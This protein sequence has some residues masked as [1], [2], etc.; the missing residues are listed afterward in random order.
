MK[1]AILTMIAVI[2][3]GSICIGAYLPAPTIPPNGVAYDVNQAPNAMGVYKCY[4]NK[5]LAGEFDVYASSNRVVSLADDGGLTIGT[6]VVTTDAN[7][8]KKYVYPWSYIPTVQGIS[9][10][11]IRMEDSLAG[12]NVREIVTDAAIDQPVIIGGCRAFGG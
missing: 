4:V 2:L 7:N 10:H 6:P 1:R 9:Y 12:V 3:I 5:V 11:S 8:V